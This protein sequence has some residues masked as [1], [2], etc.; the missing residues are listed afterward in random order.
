MSPILRKTPPALLLL[1]SLIL[2]TIPVHA[3][4]P[5]S[6]SSGNQSVTFQ[7]TRIGFDADRN[8]YG[9]GWTFENTSPDSLVFRYL[10]VSSCRDTLTGIM[11]LLSHR[12]RM[13]GALCSCD[14]IAGISISVLNER[15]GR[16]R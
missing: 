4:H 12:H 14:S 8:R 9:I 3:Q 5:V 16:A 15:K 6:V 13:G 10:I 7:W 1:G 2:A 11:T